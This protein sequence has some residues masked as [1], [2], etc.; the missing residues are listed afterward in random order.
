MNYKWKKEFEEIKE[1]SILSCFKT[2]ADGVDVMAIISISP[3][4]DELN[5]KRIINLSIY[6]KAGSVT[7][8]TYRWVVL[9][10]LDLSKQYSAHY[11][12]EF[13][14]YCLLESYY[15]RRFPKLTILFHGT[16]AYID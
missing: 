11:K 16:C 1:T 4:I 15:V 9:D 2:N 5:K 7:K 8:G 12:T 6:F 3:V 13:S 10:I 14:P